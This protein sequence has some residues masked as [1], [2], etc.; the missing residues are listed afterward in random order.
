MKEIEYFPSS[1][2]FKFGDGRQV[3]AIKG[4]VFS[5]MIAGKHCKKIQRYHYYY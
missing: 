3:T 1:A 2:K 4:V 5:T